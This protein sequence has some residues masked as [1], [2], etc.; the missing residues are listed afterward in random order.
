MRYAPINKELFRLNRA[1]LKKMLPPNALAAVNANDVL[2]VNGDAVL[3]LW[4]NSDL[5]YLTGIEQEESLLL[6]FP[7]A[8]EAKHREVLFLRQPNPLLETWEGHKLTKEEAREISGVERVE[9]LGDFPALF[10]RLM[11]ECGLVYL[12]SNENKRAQIVVQTRDA[13]FIRDVQERYPLHDYR[14]LAPLLHRLRA[15]KS[16]LEIALMRQACDITEAGFRRVCRFVKPGVNEMEVEAEFAHEFLRR[17]GRFAYNP[18]IACGLNACALH[19]VQND[20]PCRKGELLLLDVAASYANYNADMTRT[21]PVSGRFSRRQRQVYNAVLRVLR[22]ASRAATP[23]KLPKDWQSEAEQMVEKELVDL[24][25]ITLAEVK[26]QDPDDKA[27]RKYFMHGVGH[28]L[29]LDVHDLTPSAEPIQAGWVL[30]VEPAIYIRAEGFGVRLE[31]NI[32]IGEGG[33]EDL[34][35]NIPIEADEVE[36]LMQG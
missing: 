15:V 14:R 16:D 25:L 4:Q 23:G 17:G 24:G 28:P 34:M 11:C 19:Y 26:K 5:F 2:P 10:H 33:N 7:G 31:N 20:Q 27:F 30:T 1:N 36:R 3:P 9:W 21:I 6:L 8:P 13:R 18:I 35:A 29:G 12:N 32:L 22:G